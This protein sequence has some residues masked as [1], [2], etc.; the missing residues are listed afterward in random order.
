MKKYQLLIIIL[1]FWLLL[2]VEL[3]TPWV[4]NTE[5]DISHYNLYQ[6]YQGNYQKINDAPIPHPT[7]TYTFKLE[8]SGDFSGPLCFVVTAVDTSGN[9]SDYSRAVYV[10]EW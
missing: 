1:V 7:A 4:P 3:K 10:E 9:E 8:S 5:T 6:V 2:L